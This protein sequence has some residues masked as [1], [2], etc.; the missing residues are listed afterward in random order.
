MLHVLAYTKALRHVNTK[1]I[2]RSHP[3]SLQINIAPPPPPEHLSW[4]IIYK[5]NSKKD[6]IT[7]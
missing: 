2:R 7:G 5:L 4:P 6:F 3:N 1:N